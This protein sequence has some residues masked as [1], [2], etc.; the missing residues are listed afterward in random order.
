MGELV[1][2]GIGCKDGLDGGA[3]VKGVDEVR[4]PTVKRQVGCQAEVGARGGKREENG[5][6]EE[7]KSG[8]KREG[9][10]GMKGGV[11][12]QREEGSGDASQTYLT[13]LL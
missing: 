5:W 6:G 8:G 11:R 7:E 2:H 3:A 10:R 4:V 9:G 13:F 1:A 12:G